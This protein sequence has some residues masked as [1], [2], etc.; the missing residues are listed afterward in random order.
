MHKRMCLYKSHPPALGP[1][2]DVFRVPI[3]FPCDRNAWHKRATHYKLFS[4]FVAKDVHVFARLSTPG[5]FLALLGRLSRATGAGVFNAR[6]LALFVAV[7]HLWQRF[8][9]FPQ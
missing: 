2:R 6:L 3:T 9:I 1:F 5:I 7:L 8:P 4:T